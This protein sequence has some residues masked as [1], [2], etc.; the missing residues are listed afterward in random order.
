MKFFAVFAL[1]ACVAAIDWSDCDK[2]AKG[3]VTKLV[4]TPDPPAK[5]VNT[6]IVGEG[7]ISVDVAGGN[8]SLAV[9][10]DN[11]PLATETSDAC[12]PA[13]WRLPL[14]SG[15]MYW[16]GFKCPIK[17]DTTIDITLYLELSAIVP[18]GGVKTALVG[19]GTDGTHML[20]VDVNFQVGESG[21]AM[22]RQ[23]YKRK[24]LALAQ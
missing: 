24:L 5:K 6:S 14:G 7:T 19:T 18:A 11:V 22:D 15:S 10:F 2:T 23:E 8:I 12:A 16:P 20:C 21:E 13:N 9:K 3:H 17:K 4:S 1:F